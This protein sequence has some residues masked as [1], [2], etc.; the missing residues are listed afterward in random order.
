MDMQQ[1][2][3]NAEKK[4]LTATVGF[5]AVIDSIVCPVKEIVNGEKHFF[6]TIGEFGEYLQTKQKLSCMVEL[7]SRQTKIG[8]N[9]A[10][11]SNALGSLGVKVNC[12][13]SFGRPQIDPFFQSMNENC[14]LT[15]VSPTGSCTALEFNDGK[16]MLAQTDALQEMSWESIKEAVGL[17]KLYDFFTLPDMIGM[18]NWSEVLHSNEIWMGIL[19]DVLAQHKPNK[20]QIVCFDLTDFASHS[21]ED[22]LHATKIITPYFG[23]SQPSLSLNENEA[24][25][26]Y[27]VLYETAAP[28]DLKKIGDAIY[29]S[30]G[31]DTLVIHPRECSLGW[32]Q[33]DFCKVNSFFV[34]KPK[35]S[36]GGGDNFNAG[37]CYAQ[38]LGC[39][40]Y[41][42][43]LLANGVAGYYVREAAS[44][45]AE[46]L[47][48]FLQANVH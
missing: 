28:Q 26:L 39:N 46:Q 10:I 5:D 7:F 29:D 14:E 2:K 16:V 15:S 42:S 21:Q 35:I 47:M 25:L 37:L 9:M 33:N 24:R 8:G 13:G 48:D 22:V 40:L 36:T 4:E 43:M 3:R 12:I 1:W 6:S 38:M 30:M 45:T 18:L 44:P 34:Q 11:L 41:D 32:E 23:R 20:K 27:R 31:I 17:P 19:T